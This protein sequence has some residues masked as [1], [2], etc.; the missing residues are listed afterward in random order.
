MKRKQMTSF[1]DSDDKKKAMTTAT[2][3]AQKEESKANEVI[4]QRFGPGTKTQKLSNLASSFQSKEFYAKS[5]SNVDK[6]NR[7]TDNYEIV[8]KNGFDKLEPQEIKYLF[9]RKG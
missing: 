8:T 9:T 4:S 5:Y 7:T 1:F 3:K 6:Q 2:P